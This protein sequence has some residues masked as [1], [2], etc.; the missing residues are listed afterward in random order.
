MGS[1]VHSLGEERIGQ[2]EH[3]DSEGGQNITELLHMFLG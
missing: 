3:L 1:I 2:E